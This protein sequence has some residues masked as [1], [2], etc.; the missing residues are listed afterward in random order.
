M[1][2]CCGPELCAIA[3]A[4]RNMRSVFKFAIHVSLKCDQILIF[5]ADSSITR[6]FGRAVMSSI[7]GFTVINKGEYIEPSI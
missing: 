4:H 2:Q 1:D 7:F 3:M 5:D 6:E